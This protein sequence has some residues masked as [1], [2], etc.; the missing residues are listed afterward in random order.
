MKKVKGRV[1]GGNGQHVTVSVALEIVITNN[2]NNIKKAG[3]SMDKAMANIVGAFTKQL[4]PL[5]K[6][7]NNLIIFSKS[8][9][10]INNLIAPLHKKFIF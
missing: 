10:I 4:T 2:N 9:L 5:Y 7:V 6:K 8:I 1:S 3:S